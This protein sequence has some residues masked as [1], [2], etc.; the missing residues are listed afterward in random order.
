MSTSI[1][2]DYY[3][4]PMC[5]WSWAFQPVLE[6]IRRD[7]RDRVRIRYRMLPIYEDISQLTDQGHIG[8]V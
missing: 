8:S 1:S 4:D 3:T 7:Y 2:V 6:R 5:P